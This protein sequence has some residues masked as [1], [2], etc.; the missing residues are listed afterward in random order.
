MPNF[1]VSCCSPIRR[2]ARRSQCRDR[3]STSAA[4]PSVDRG[5]SMT[6]PR[7]VRP[8]RN[9]DCPHCRSWDLRRR[10]SPARPFTRTRAAEPPP[11][12]LRRC[13]WCRRTW[14][15]R[16]RAAQSRSRHQRRQ[17]AGQS[18]ANAW[19]P[20]VQRRHIIA[21]KRFGSVPHAGVREHGVRS[22]A[23]PRDPSAA[24]AWADSRPCPPP[25]THPRHPA[26]RTRSS[27]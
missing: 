16:R 13:S 2:P 20:A 6:R 19:A 11:T 9:T 26:G 15:E 8:A 21:L 1:D 12:T 4:C 25:G 24:Q 23:A 22:V 27:R 14:R 5:R 18:P 7:G 17:G 3:G 10:S